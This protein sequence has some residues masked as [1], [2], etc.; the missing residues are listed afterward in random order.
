M[1]TRCMTAQTAFEVQCFK[2][3]RWEIRS[4][5][6][7]RHTALAEADR[8]ERRGI[9]RLRVVQE[10]MDGDCEL[11]HSRTI[12]QT[13]TVEE[14]EPSPKVQKPAPAKSK[15]AAPAKEA[16]VR[17]TAKPAKKASDKDSWTRIL[18]TAVVLLSVAVG[19][20]VVLRT[21]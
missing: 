17:R 18:V 14:A 13:G 1:E 9:K 21:L 20:L 12:Y 4:I 6:D 5:F 2:S 3:G 7:D 10:R 19:A 8:L 15:P 16:P 11:I